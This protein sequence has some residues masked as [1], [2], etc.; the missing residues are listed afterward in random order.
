MRAGWYIGVLFSLAF[1]LLP[2][3]SLVFSIMEPTGTID[4]ILAILLL[5][6]FLPLGV[7]IGKCV[8]EERKEAR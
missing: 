2:L 3:A 4:W 5:L 8:L 7:L 1:I 6:I